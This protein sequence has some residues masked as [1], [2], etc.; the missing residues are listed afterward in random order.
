[1]LNRFLTAIACFALLAAPALAA[2]KR[3]AARPDIYAPKDEFGI[4]H[5][6]WAKNAVIY[7]INTRQFT[8]EGTFKAAQKQLPRLQALGVDIL[9]L[10]PVHPIG[11]KNRKGSLGSPYSVQDYYGV[12]PEF[13]TKDDLR[14]FIANAHQ[15][16]MKVI[17]DWVA[18]H[19]AWDNPW[20]A[21][22]PD[23]YT[24]DWKGDFHSTKW[25]DW[26]DIIDLDYSKPGLRRAMT[27]AMVYWVKDM[28]IDGFRC[29]V[30][31]FVPLDFWQQVR[32]ELDPIKPVFLL[33]E[34]QNRDMHY[35]AFNATYS[36]Q[37]NDAMHRIGKGQADVGAVQ[38]FYAENDWTFPRQAMRMIHIANH[39]QNSWDATARDRFGPATDAAIVLSF[40]GAGIPMMYNGQ[41]AGDPKKLAFFERDPIPWEK[42][43]MEDLYR[44][45]IALKS[46]NRALWNAPW[47][48][49]MDPVVNDQPQ[50]VFSFTRAAGGDKVF[51]VFNLSAA[52]QTVRFT[53]GPF[54]GAYVEHFTGAHE[55]FAAQS[56]LTLPAWSYRVYIA[57]K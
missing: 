5:P 40:I 28:N 29:D 23:W 54:A 9:W 37:W 57:A 49:E 35:R 17:I 2:P 32:R 24:R 15:H 13:G 34:S 55:T 30:A 7:Q 45:L 47:G 50:K 10:M 44:T 21:Q 39:D 8:P 26:A 33:A 41:E 20:A 48:G 31:H 52:A 12:N 25:T 19:T 18:N 4:K 36:W 27:A 1:M 51:A 46:K 14:A 38:G 22:H 56:S 3:P 11:V 42:D 6:D 53:D 43:P 16:D